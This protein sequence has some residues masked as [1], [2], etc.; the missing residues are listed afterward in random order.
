MK[1]L[2][3][4]KKKEQAT[5]QI[6]VNVPKDVIAQ[7]IAGKVI[8]LN[9]I[10][11]AVFSSGMMGKGCGIIP[12]SEK[13]YAPTD[14]TVSL[15]ADT[16][17]AVGIIA[18]NGAQI[19]MHIGLETV[20]MNGKGFDVY[21]K[22]GDRVKA[23]QLLLSFSFKEIEA[24][25]GVSTTSAVIF[26]NPADFKSIELLHTGESSTGDALFKLIS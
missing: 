9:E 8:E 2:D 6:E 10:D 17:H 13:V 7:P 26:S 15:V 11:D 3:L 16:K 23:G 4:V 20:S 24:T 21:V 12:T 22:P 25:P 1:I 19:L 5:N 14:G 18:D